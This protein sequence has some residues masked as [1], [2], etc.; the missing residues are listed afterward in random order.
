MELQT[1]FDKDKYI[2]DHESN[3]MKLPQVEIQT[4][5][6]LYGGI[7]TRRIIIPKGCIM[8]GAVYKKDFISI[9]IYGD[10]NLLNDDGSETRV[11]G[12]NAFQS[13]PGARRMGISHEESMWIGIFSTEALDID[14]VL[15]EYMDET[16]TDMSKFIG[17]ENIKLEGLSWSEQ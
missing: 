15:M 14:S 9:Q 12:Y 11:T 3:V 1:Q 4:E 10:M 7:Y 6:M 8:T 13:K 17:I 5:H 2:T 16:K